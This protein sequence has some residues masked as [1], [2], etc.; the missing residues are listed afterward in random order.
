M[1]RVSRRPDAKAD[2]IQVWDYI[3]QDNREAADTFLRRLYKQ[4]ELI[5]TQPL[6]GGSAQSWAKTFAA[7]RWGAT[8]FT[9]NLLKTVSRLCAC[10]T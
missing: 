10:C 1:P 2:L 9:T 6:M 5:A 4:F 3:A 7:I 8:L